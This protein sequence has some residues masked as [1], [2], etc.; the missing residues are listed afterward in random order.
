[1]AQSKRILYCHCKYAKIIAP[2]VK[3][4][5][6]KALCDSGVSFDAVPDLCEMSAR[7]DPALARLAG[8]GR[9]TIAACYPRAVKWLFHA[10]G[11][12]LHEETVQIC[13]MRTTGAEEIVPLL[14]DGAAVPQEQTA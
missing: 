7:K 5:V 6:L 12:A 3:E 1:M 10:A 14:L 11:A 2:E 9:L 13:N 4:R 8:G